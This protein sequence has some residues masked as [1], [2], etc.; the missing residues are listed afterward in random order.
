M[1]KLKKYHK[2]PKMKSSVEVW[3]RYEERC[4]E[5]DRYNNDLK[6]REAEKKRIIDKVRK[7]KQVINR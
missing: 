4:R 6:R 2:Q 3:K 5:V 1:A 7:M